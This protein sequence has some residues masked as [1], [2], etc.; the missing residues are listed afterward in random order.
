MLSTC[1]TFV[2]TFN[3]D[4]N[5]NARN[6]SRYSRLSL[7]KLN[8]KWP[9]KRCRHKTSKK[10][11]IC[12]HNFTN[13]DKNQIRSFSSKLVASPSCLSPVSSC[14]LLVGQARNLG[15]GFFTSF[16]PPPPWLGIRLL[17]RLAKQGKATV[18]ILEPRGLRKTLGWDSPTS[19]SCRLWKE[20]FN[21]CEFRPWCM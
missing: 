7:P 16:T 14:F 4:W 1:R 5:T 18:E 8:S 9:P 20:S 21:L 12:R 19:A 17:V 3:V 6:T 11:S 2:A 10:R 13:I 15:V